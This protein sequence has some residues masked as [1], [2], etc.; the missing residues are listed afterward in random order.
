MMG[1]ILSTIG[2]YE[3]LY[4]ERYGLH[5]EINV[6]FIP[7]YNSF[8]FAV[9]YNKEVNFHNS[10][11]ELLSEHYVSSELLKEV[12]SLLCNSNNVSS[13]ILAEDLDCNVIHTIRYYGEERGVL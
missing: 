4:N 3:I 9:R 6:E 7:N 12:L 8:G 2:I 11:W 5:A 13:Y 10:L 1:Q